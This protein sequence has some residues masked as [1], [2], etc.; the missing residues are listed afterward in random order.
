M[1]KETPVLL[2]STDQDVRGELTRAIAETGRAPT[3]VE[4]G[5]RMNLPASVIKSAYERLHEAHALLLHPHCCEPWAVHP[6]ALSPGSCWVEAGT[7]GWWAN[8]MYCGMGILAAIRSDGVIH[9]RIGGERE[10][11]SVHIS[12]DSVSAPELLFHL[13]TPV[14]YWWNNVIHSCATFQPFRS[15]ADIDDW[16]HRHGLERG[17]AIPL[18]QMQRFAKDWYGGYLQ[19]PWRKR[20]AEEAKAIFDRHGFEGDFWRL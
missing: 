2:T 16:C 5:N 4:L 1:S 18:M 15:S 6:F 3:I 7:R 11:I 9:T 14:R 19:S 12:A 20:T 8:C 10:A 17:A 13:A